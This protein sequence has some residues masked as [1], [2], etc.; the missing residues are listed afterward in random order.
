[1][2]IHILSELVAAQIAAGEVVERPASVIKE[3]VENALDADSGDIRIEVEEGGRR[4]L[5]VS[6]DGYGIPA[7]EVA[8]AFS[9]HATSKITDIDDL[10]SI[11]T[12]GFR[13]EALHSIAAVSRVTLTTRHADESAGT[14]LRVH[15]GDAQAARPIGAPPGTVITV[16][17]L[18]Y[19][20][21]ARLKF[22]KGVTTER[23]RI[24]Q[25]VTNYALAYPGVRFTLHHDGRE[26]FRTYG[27]G[28]LADVLAT[29]LGPDVFRSML[30]VE[31][32][33]P[34]RPD[35]PPIS[36]TG[37]TSAPDL[38][39][40]NRSHITLFVNGRWIQDSSLTHAVV[41]AYHTLLPKGRAPV[42]VILITMPPQE[43]DVNVHPTKAEVRFRSADAVFSAVQRAVR[44]AV[45]DQAPTPSINLDT[46]WQQSLPPRWESRR[47]DTGP[48]PISRPQLRQP[49]LGL[50]LES[51]GS[52][53][54]QRPLPAPPSDDDLSAIPAGLGRP[55]R[56]RT[57]PMLRVMGQVGAS[58][59][60]AEGPAGLYL[61]DQ[62]AAHERILFEQ[63]MAEQASHQT[64]AQ[65]TLDAVTV[66]LPMEA[67]ALVEENLDVLAEV[68]FALEPFGGRTFRVRA[69]PALL[70]GQDPGE[71]VRIIVEDLEAGARPGQATLEE[72]ISL[73]VC[74]A[75]A[76][77]AGQ[78]LSMTEM[79]SIIRQL[80]RCDSPHT[81]PHG[82]PTLIHI[83]AVQLAKEFGRT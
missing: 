20:T 69:V 63:F 31:P 7:D 81:C 73:R 78:V 25:L 27:T 4:L 79:Q 61:I 32:L 64:V 80:E 52:Y 54:Q 22:L 75:A 29:T 26:V 3:L 9:R 82:R 50:E 11:D 6:D 83:S 10:S 40:A 21:P 55:D 36:V 37:Y 13:G 59:I 24:T 43:V 77:K 66:E 58:Y 19:N 18:F 57:L 23:R 38:N 41:Q 8:L 15:G 34:S 42:A 71:A 35:L 12:L 46:T 30:P 65:H 16:E 14:Q 51:P 74:K 17:D 39:R 53:S 2:A 48:G 67:A 62:H 76:V 45:V 72:Q 49:G 5:R 70:A 60:V 28:Q 68:G 1:M 33:P 56:P 44:S 47:D